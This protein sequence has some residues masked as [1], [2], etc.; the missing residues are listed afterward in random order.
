[1]VDS[2]ETKYLTESPQKSSNMVDLDEELS[3]YTFKD[4][5]LWLICGHTTILLAAFV[6]EIMLLILSTLSFLFVSHDPE[7]AAI[8]KLDFF[9]LGVTIFVTLTLLI[10]CARRQ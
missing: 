5:L 1:M 9:L 7:T 2:L 4:R 3:S 10:L 6:L 8:L